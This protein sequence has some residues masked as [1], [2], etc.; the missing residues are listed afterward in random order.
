MWTPHGLATQTGE[1]VFWDRSTL[2]GFR[3]V[4]RAG[5]TDLALRYLEAFTRRR[6]L[7]DHV[8]YPI[9]VGPKGGQQHLFSESAL[10]C[11]V[12]NEGL[13]GILPSGLDRFRCTPQLPD[14]WPRMAMRSIL[15]FGRTWD[16]VV[17]RREARLGIIVEQHGKRVLDR[18]IEKGS[19]TDIVLP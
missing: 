17:E 4:L 1:T 5:E 15:A 2:Y 18:T 13:F 12:L 3:G 6:L 11:R 8:P 14:A 16:I 10:Y 7:G 9:E 19:A